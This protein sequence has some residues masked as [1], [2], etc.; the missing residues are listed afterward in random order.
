MQWICGFDRATRYSLGPL[1][2]PFDHARSPHEFCENY[3]P[4]RFLSDA[5]MVVNQNGPVNYASSSGGASIVTEFTSQTHGRTPC[6]GSK[7]EIWAC[8]LEKNAHIN[9]P[10]VILEDG[11]VNGECWEFSGE[12]GQVAIN[13]TEPVVITHISLDRPA[14]GARSRAPKNLTLWALV[15]NRDQHSGDQGTVPSELPRSALRVRPESHSRVQNLLDFLPLYPSDTA[16]FVQ[17]LSFEYDV[18]KAAVSG[19]SFFIQDTQ[20]KVQTVL[21]KVDGNFGGET[22]CLP[23]VGIYST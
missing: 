9:S 18:N 6:S 20:I 22:T 14:Q 3:D 12:K 17:I 5:F 11:L 19:Q 13:L 23:P 4:F 16:S 15:N 2:I 10:A 1:C 7:S 21:L 8:N